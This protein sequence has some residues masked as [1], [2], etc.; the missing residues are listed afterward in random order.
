MNYQFTL[1]TREYKGINQ[2][3]IFRYEL[4]IYFMHLPIRPIISILFNIQYEIQSD[5]YKKDRLL[6][7]YE[8]PIYCKHHEIKTKSIKCRQTTDLDIGVFGKDF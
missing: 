2:I 8:L 6:F 1:Y 4:P 3:K 5:I 7:R